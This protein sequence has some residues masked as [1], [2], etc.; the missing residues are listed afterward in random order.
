MGG[1]GGGDADMA[2][3]IQEDDEAMARR[4]QG[5]VWLGGPDGQ[6]SWHAACKG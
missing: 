2:Q 5:W 1:G 3:H 4:L 6:G